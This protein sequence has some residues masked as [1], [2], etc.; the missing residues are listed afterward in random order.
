MAAAAPSGAQRAP[1]EASHGIVASASLL[2]SS[3]GVDIL[4]RGGNSI[5]A[6][7]ATAFALA[8]TYPRAGNLG[9]GG[10]AVLRLADGRTASVDFRETGPAGAWRDLYLDAQR[11]VIPDRSTVGDLAAGVPGTVA[12][13]GLLL[14]KYGS[15]R[16]TW[17]QA[18]EPARELAS[19]G[20]RV[21]PALARDLRAGADLLERF[22]ES[23]RVFLRGGRFYQA[24]E[25]FRQPE[26][27]ATLR[28]IQ[29]AGAREFYEGE[30]AALITEEMRAHGG[31]I[32]RADL[33]AY[34]PVERA[35]LRG[36]YR[37]YEIVTMPPPS[38]GGVA[39][40]QMLGMLEP[41]DVAALGL[42]SAAKVHLFAEVMRRAFRD[43]AQY[44]GDPDFVSV[45]VARLLDPAYLARQMVDFNPARA[46]NNEALKSAEALESGDAGPGKGG[47]APGVAAA[48][49]NVSL[50]H[51]SSQTTHFSIVDSAG[52]AVSVTYTL[53][54]LWGNG[55]TVPGAGFLLN[56]EMDDFAAKVGV[57]NSFGL[58]QGD[59]NA[60]APGKRPLSS[61]TPTIA[62]KNGQPFLITGSPGG[63]TIINTVLLVLTNVIDH[64]LS[65]TEAVDAPRFHHQWQPDRIDHEGFFASPDTLAI[66]E[67]EGYTLATRGP[68]PHAPKTGVRSWGDAESILIDPASGLRQGAND[69]RSADS[70]AVGW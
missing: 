4:R 48:R 40:L 59:S 68:Y 23:K 53:N 56:N 66:L 43:R 32:T 58:I 54:G 15:H 60:I 5:D 1:V 12:G 62:S 47:V 26:L 6:A 36:S 31:L 33:S 16:I 45:P 19:K 63:P 34:R 61:M 70:A 35:V 37:G 52:N 57:P 17:S 67:G 3:A 51:E 38:S 69:L 29:R 8:V 20:F 41:Y 30:T 24:G 42:N 46:S 39:L 64:G 7:V 9:G 27:A 2:A 50:A 44:L 55:V 13:L 25:W 28:R 18:V 11:N 10:F 49:S 14:E 65:L 21:T 22:P